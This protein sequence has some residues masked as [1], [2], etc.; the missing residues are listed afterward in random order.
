MFDSKE[1]VDE[2]PLSEQN[3]QARA[4]S[5]QASWPHESKK[6]WKCKIK[7]LVEA[8]WYFDPAPADEDCVS[9]AYCGLSLGGWEPKDDPV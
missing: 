5:F 9:C 2:D 1:A 7:K 4:D 8:G 3:S 6:G